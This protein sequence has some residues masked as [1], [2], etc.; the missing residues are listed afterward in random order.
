M[1]PHMEMLFKKV[2][3]GHLLR[4]DEHYEYLT[5]ANSLSLTIVK[6]DLQRANKNLFD[7]LIYRLS[8]EFS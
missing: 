8:A 3:S 6:I 7:T 2:N 4:I 5:S 1:N